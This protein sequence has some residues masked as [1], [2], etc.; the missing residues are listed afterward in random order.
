[1]G[2]AAEAAIAVTGA[3]WHC[4]TATDKYS[5][6]SQLLASLHEQSK[7]SHTFE[8]CRRY[9]GFRIPHF[10]GAICRP[11]KHSFTCA[12]PNSFQLL[13]LAANWNALDIEN[14]GLPSGVNPPQLTAS[15]WPLKT[16]MQVASGAFHIHTDPSL[17]PARK[18][19]PFGCQQPHCPGARFTKACTLAPA[20]I[21]NGDLLPLSPL[22][23]LPNLPHVLQW[24]LPKSV[25]LVI[26]MPMRTRRCIECTLMTP[27]RP[28]VA[29]YF[30]SPLKSTYMTESECPEWH[31]LTIQK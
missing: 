13:L 4:P 19:G 14:G 18:T 7:W 28:A 12:Q 24:P 30:P 27:S 22:L 25:P 6:R 11:C 5:T 2:L 16:I 29:K 15:P 26:T 20:T 3:L 10:H 17:Q 21:N 8:S 31:P 1:M 9:S 23:M